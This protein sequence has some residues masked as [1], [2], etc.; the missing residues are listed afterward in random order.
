MISN[1]IELSKICPIDIESHLYDI[2]TPEGKAYDI[3]NS[4]SYS[5]YYKD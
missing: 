2:N 1:H 5:L 3:L 4:I